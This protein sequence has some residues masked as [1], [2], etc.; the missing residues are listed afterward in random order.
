M[1]PS[2]QPAKGDVLNSSPC[3]DPDLEDEVPEL[4][5]SEEDEEDLVDALDGI[6][7]GDPVD[8]RN[9]S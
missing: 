9:A 5:P 2:G 6:G 7:L 1:T 4:R 3:V 8:P